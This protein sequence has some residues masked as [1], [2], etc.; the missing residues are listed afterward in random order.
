MFA[1]ADSKQKAQLCHLSATLST[2]LYIS[3]IS[4]VKLFSIHIVL[5]FTDAVFGT[6]SFHAS[7]VRYS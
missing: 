5:L 1:A 3:H 2:D 6:L 7:F 4:F